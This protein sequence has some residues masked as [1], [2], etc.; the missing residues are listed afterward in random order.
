MKASD[1][2]A[3]LLK[4]PDHKVELGKV[5]A[6]PKPVKDKMPDAYEVRLDF[7][8]VGLASGLDIDRKTGV[9]M[10]VIDGDQPHYLQQFGKVIK[11]EEELE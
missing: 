10:L 5:I 4:N 7:P 11:L 2:A 3:E 9:T 1:L 8:I 6:T